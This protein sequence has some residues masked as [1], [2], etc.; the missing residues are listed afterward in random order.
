MITPQLHLIEPTDTS[1]NRRSDTVSDEEIQGSRIQGIIDRMLEMSAGKGKAKEDSRQ[2]VG[3]AA[4]QLGTNKRVITIDLTADGSNKEQRLQVVI[5][6]VITER[7]GE[8]VDGREGCWSCGNICGNVERF[9]HVTLEGV[10]RTGRPVRFELSEFVARIAQHETDHLD[11]VRFPDR[12]PVDQPE[13][14]H[15]V[16]PTQFEEYRQNWQNWPIICPRERWQQMK[17]GAAEI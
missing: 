10:N 11:G 5:N 14:L 7:S 2:M 17:K 16:E 15:W 12:I 1:L 13:R 6:P 9:Q 3:L 4:S 8:L